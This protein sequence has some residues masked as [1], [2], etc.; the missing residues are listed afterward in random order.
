MNDAP[1]SKNQC[2]NSAFESNIESVG[3]KK[4]TNYYKK[5][6][7]NMINSRT[8]ETADLTTSKQS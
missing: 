7:P 2:Y 4:S 6:F 5:S 1:K 8:K 3:R